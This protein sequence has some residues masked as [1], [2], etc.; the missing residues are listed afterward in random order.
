MVVSE[1]FWPK[2]SF[3]MTT[4]PS[5]NGT[6]SSIKAKTQKIPSDEWMILETAV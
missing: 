4:E 5:D 6:A 2:G 1:N 3:S